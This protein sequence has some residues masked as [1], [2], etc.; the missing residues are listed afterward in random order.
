MHAQ[1]PEPRRRGQTLDL[2]RRTRSGK[3]PVDLLLAEHLRKGGPPLGGGDRPRRVVGP[4][5]VGKEMPVELAQGGQAP[6]LRARRIAAAG[7]VGEI[8]GEVLARRS[9]RCSL[10]GGQ[11]A[12]EVVEIAAVAFQRVVGGA[13]FGRQHLQEA[14]DQQRVAGHAI[15]PTT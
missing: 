7:E 14:L 4:Q 15:L 9:R 8:G 12:G 13:A 1:R 3:Q 6:G 10:A 5:P 11:E 2:A